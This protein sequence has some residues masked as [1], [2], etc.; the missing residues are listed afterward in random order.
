[1][2]VLEDLANAFYLVMWIYLRV[3]YHRGWRLEWRKPE[4]ES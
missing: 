2:K 3:R 4:K 1:M